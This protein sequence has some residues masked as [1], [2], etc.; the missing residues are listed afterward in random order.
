MP[1]LN[2]TVPFPPK[3]NR[4][5]PFSP[6]KLFLFVLITLGHF[7][8]S[9]ICIGKASFSYASAASTRKWQLAL[10]I[11]NFPLVYLDRLNYMSIVPLP[12]GWD[13]YTILVVL[14]SILW[15][16][17]LTLIFV[18]VKNKIIRKGNT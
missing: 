16:L 13:W 7:V 8:F 18:W 5:V 4:T 17:G 11:A 1:K 12:R 6:A 15:G 10:D 14:N 2:R 9:I 3:L